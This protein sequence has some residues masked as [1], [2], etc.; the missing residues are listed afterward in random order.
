M[1]SQLKTALALAGALAV[2][3]ASGGTAGAQTGQELFAAKG[4]VACHGPTGKKSILPIYPKLAGQYAEYLV[5][6]LKAFKTQERKGPQAALMWG[7]AAQLSE[8]EM[9]KISDFLAKVK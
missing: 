9:Q 8:A 2:V 1:T 5:L 7:M 3:L 6:Q 4:C